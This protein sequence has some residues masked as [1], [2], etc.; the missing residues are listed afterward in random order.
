MTI[1]EQL[2]AARERLVAAGIPP[3]EAVLDAELL[4]RHALGWDRVALVA[5]LPD[6]APD[7][8]PEAYAPLVARRSAREPLAYIIGVQEFWGRP[9]H[10]GPGVLIP[11]PETELIVEEALGWAGTRAPGADGV[12]VLD[13]GTGSGCLAITLALELT[14]ARVSAT[15]VSGAAL[16]IARTNA[17]RLGATVDFQPGACLAACAG[18]F[19]LIVS[20]PPYVAAP[21]HAGLAPEVREHEPVTALVAGEDGLDVIREIVGGAAPAMARGGRL[22]VEVGH[23]QAAAVTKILADAEGLRLLRIREDLQGIPR[24]AVI[25]STR[26]GTG[27]PG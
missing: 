1:H 19:D 3:V 7:G 2:R 16:A 22:L 20:N 11:R 27:S 6:P 10:V 21:A 18:P 9:F 12:R 8:F 24:V 15:D 14:G 25:A 23:D 13:I 17:E 5:R 26:P 4:A